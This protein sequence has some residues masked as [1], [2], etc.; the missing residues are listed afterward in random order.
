MSRTVYFFLTL[1][2]ILTDKNSIMR[3]TCICDRD[4]S[5]TVL[6]N[7]QRRSGFVE[8][9]FQRLKTSINLVSFQYFD[10]NS[11]R[12]LKKKKSFYVKYFLEVV[13][14]NSLINSV[15]FLEDS[16]H[17][18]GRNHLI[19][20]T[21][22]WVNSHTLHLILSSLKFSLISYDYIRASLHSPQCLP[23]TTPSYQNASLLTEGFFGCWI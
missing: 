20:Y 14:V 17:R 12:E 10:S 8:I 11:F 18:V 3:S 22:F 23:A 16:L 13:L 1:Q 9:G 4:N 2:C 6:D 21:F 15:I 5:T 19:H 7:Y